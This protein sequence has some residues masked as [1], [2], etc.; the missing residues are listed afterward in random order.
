MLQTHAE[1]GIKLTGNGQSGIGILDVVVRQLLAVQLFGRGQREGH[2]LLLA[3]ELRCL[4][5]VL[6]IAQ[7]LHQVELQ[8]ELLVQ[9]GLLAHVGRDHRIVLRRMRISLGRKGQTGL[10]QRIA[11]S[12]DLVQNLR[13]VLGVANHRHV[14]PILGCRTQHRRTAN[15]DILDCLLDRHTLL[16]NRLTEG[17]EIHAD[18]VDKLDL[19]LLEGLQVALIVTTS[20]QTAMHLRVERLDTTITNLREARYIADIDHLNTLLFEEFHR[21]ARGDHLPAQ[22]AKSLCK[23]HHTRLITYRN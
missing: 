6:T 8:K 15:V 1:R 10:L 5:R 7:R 13:I 2:S 14:S 4:M 20:Q 22:C 18:H 11:M 21:T 16:L 3:V 9:T 19:I 12:L 17:I 23:L